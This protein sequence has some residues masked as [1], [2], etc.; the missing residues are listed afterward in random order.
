MINFAFDESGESLAMMSMCKPL[1]VSRA[2]KNAL[3]INDAT[4]KQP[5]FL[6][7]KRV[8]TSCHFIPQNLL[9]IFGCEVISLRILRL[10]FIQLEE[11]LIFNVK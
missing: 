11:R 3:S 2:L 5:P 8:D 6:T 7:Q 9:P 4:H 1:S 10:A